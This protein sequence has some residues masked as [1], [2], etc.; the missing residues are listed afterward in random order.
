MKVPKSYVGS[1][2]AV[3]WRDPVSMRRKELHEAKVGMDALATWT[4]Y[5]MLD[6]LTDGVLRIC[7][8]EGYDGNQDKRDEI[9]YTAVWEVLV[10]NIRRLV[11]EPVLSAPD[12]QPQ[13][14]TT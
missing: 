8:S 2:V 7:H 6:D 14:V 9:C 10:T 12:S 13:N 11:D 4:E 5:G 1:V 3:T